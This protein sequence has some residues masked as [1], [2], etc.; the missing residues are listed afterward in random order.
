MQVVFDPTDQQGRTFQPFA[1]PS[2]VSVQFLARGFVSEEGP[3]LFG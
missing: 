2:K 3:A 1:D